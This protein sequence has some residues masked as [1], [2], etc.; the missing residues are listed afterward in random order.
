MRLRRNFWR[1][2]PFIWD[3][4]NLAKPIGNPM[5]KDSNE[6]NYDRDRHGGGSKQ[7]AFGGDER[8]LTQ[9]APHP[10]TAA[11]FARH[12]LWNLL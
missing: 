7:Q 11:I 4:Q 1:V 9:N 10:F 2:A 12:T 6:G 8:H 3:V 5:S